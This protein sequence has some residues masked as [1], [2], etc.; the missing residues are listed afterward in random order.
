MGRAVRP[1]RSGGGCVRP[2][3]NAGRRPALTTSDRERMKELERD[4]PKTEKSIALRTGRTDQY[5]TG[6][7][8]ESENAPALSVASL[9]RLSITAMA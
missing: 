4:F 7:A 6:L 1:R 3:R 8:S 9:R 2:K 5:P